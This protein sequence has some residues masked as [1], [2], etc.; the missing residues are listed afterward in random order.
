MTDHDYHGPA[1]IVRSGWGSWRAVL[2]SL[3]APKGYLTVK[4][5]EPGRGWSKQPIQV[6][7]E[8]V[9]LVPVRALRLVEGGA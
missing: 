6:R 5:T 7:R 3:P 8:L 9:E 1:V 2:V 4:P